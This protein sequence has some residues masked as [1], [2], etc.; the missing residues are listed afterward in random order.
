M[1][2]PTPSLILLFPSSEGDLPGEVQVGAF[3]RD[4]ASV[5]FLGRPSLVEIDIWSDIGRSYA[6]PGVPFRCWYAGRIIGSGVVLGDGIEVPV[7]DS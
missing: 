4:P 2:S 1:P 6:T 7:G 5:L 3:I